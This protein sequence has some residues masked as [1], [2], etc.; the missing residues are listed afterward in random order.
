MRFGTTT[1]GAELNWPTVVRRQHQ[2]V[3]ELQPRP[4]S[5]EDMGAT[6]VLGEARFADAHTVAVNGSE[7]AGLLAAQIA[8]LSDPSL[9]AKVEEERA[10]RKKKVLESD[11]EVRA[12]TKG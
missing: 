12:E 10:A 1:A 5:L 6:V 2:I 11:A 4:A 9:A 7:N 8:A 3:E